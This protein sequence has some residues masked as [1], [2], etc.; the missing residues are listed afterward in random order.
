MTGPRAPMTAAPTAPGPPAVWARIEAGGGIDDPTGG[1]R[2][3]LASAAAALERG[4]TPRR[5]LAA[6]AAA[7]ARH[8]MGAYWPLYA[9]YAAAGDR[10]P[11]A[12]AAE[13]WAAIEEWFAALSVLEARLVIAEAAGRVAELDDR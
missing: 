4:E 9:S 1:H 6:M 3:V 7:A 10:L 11:A 2:A 13:E 8:G 12:S 5:A